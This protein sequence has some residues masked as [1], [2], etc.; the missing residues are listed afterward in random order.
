VCDSEKNDE[1]VLGAET[2]EATIDT[3]R[4]R[5]EGDWHF[6]SSPIKPAHPDE[7]KKIVPPYLYNGLGRYG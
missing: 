7:M 6:C 3:P 2:G 4:T 1:P 5:K